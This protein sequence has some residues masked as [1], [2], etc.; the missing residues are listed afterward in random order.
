MDNDKE[1]MSKEFSNFLKEKDIMHQ[2]NV[3]YISQQNGILERTNH[4]L[5]EIARYIMLQANLPRS[6]WVEALNMT[7][8]L[9]NRSA[10]KSLDEMTLKEKTVHWLPKDYRKQGYSVEQRH[11]QRKVSTKK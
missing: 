6:M 9:G 5:V 8:Y 11:I 10:T 1:Y 3:E 4:T 2:L 7:A